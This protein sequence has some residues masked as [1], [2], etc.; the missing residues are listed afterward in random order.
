MRFEETPIPGAYLIH[1]DRFEDDRGF[2][3][4][5]WCRDELGDQGL[6]A[7]L[8]QASMS[9]NP[10][11][12]TLR[13]LHFQRAPH[14]ETK[15]VR[16]VRGAIYDVIVDLR[17]GSEAYLDWFA[18]ELDARRGG[19]LYIPAGVAH[20]FQTL[21]DDTDVLYLIS[22]PYAPDHAAGV[23]WDDPAFGV[24]WPAT[25]VRTISDRDRSWPPYE[26]AGSLRT[27]GT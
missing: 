24:Q 15:I 8:S 19:A 25:A 13:G 21:A 14:E 23:A 11:H 27:L 16:C 5:I 10:K 18:L 6:D 20:G 7:G 3:A 4:R 22:M 9:H 17:V 12:G 26:P 1:D 2:F